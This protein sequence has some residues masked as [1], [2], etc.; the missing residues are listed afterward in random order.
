[1]II[2]NWDKI[3]EQLLNYIK[4]GKMLIDTH[5]D[6]FD[7]SAEMRAEAVCALEYAAASLTRM[8]TINLIQMEGMSSSMVNK[9][10]NCRIDFKDFLPTK[11]TTPIGTSQSTGHVFE[12]YNMVVSQTRKLVGDHYKIK[13]IKHIT[14]QEDEVVECEDGFEFDLDEDEEL[15]LQVA[16]D[17]R[18]VLN[19]DGTFINENSLR[20]REAMQRHVASFNSLQS[21]QTG[22]IRR[23]EEYDQIR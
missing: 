1:M 3:E 17:V 9:V 2:D 22:S 15:P 20:L 18:S 10:N 5:Y 6:G 14:P 13:Y 19:E 7:M 4:S 11:I 12:Y 8:S 16:E 21:N 23:W